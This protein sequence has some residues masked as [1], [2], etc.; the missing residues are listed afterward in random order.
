MRALGFCALVVGA[1]L[2]VGTA[3][4]RAEGIDV[5]STYSNSR[6]RAGSSTSDDSGS[7]GTSPLWDVSTS[8]SQGDATATSNVDVSLLEASITLGWATDATDTDNFGGAYGFVEFTADGALVYVLDGGSGFT[9]GTGTARYEISL[10]DQT[11]STYAFRSYQR[12][13]D[14][15]D[16]SFVAGGT[17]GT[18][19]NTL[20]G[21]LTGTLVDGHDYLFL[22]SGEVANRLSHL[23]ALTGSATGTL[24]LGAPVPEPT[25]LVL[26]SLGAAGLAVRRRRHRTLG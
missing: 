22:V 24:T 14:V 19:T 8:A 3:A 7:Y 13:N 23:N 12:S 2:V 9:G 25:T 20:L 4:A 21:S 1:L 26:F 17:A 18:T 5:T 15:A 16:A 11:T 6:A 10:F